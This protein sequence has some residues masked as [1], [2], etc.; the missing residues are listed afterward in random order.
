MKNEDEAMGPDRGITIRILPTEL[1]RITDRI[2]RTVDGRVTDDSII[3]PTE[4]MEIDR[5][6]EISITKLELGEI[7]EIF[8]VHH[9]EKD[10]T[11]LK[12]ILSANPYL[13]NQ[14]IC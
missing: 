3:S 8:L 2:I 5:I 12:V 6:M 7:M 4:T 11:F 1:I 13:F 10:K 14:K 9:Q